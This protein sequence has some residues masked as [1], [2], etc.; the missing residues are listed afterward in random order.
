MQPARQPL[1]NPTMRWFL[2]AMIIANIA[3]EMFYSLLPIYLAE[4]GSSIEQI[5]LV[6][7]LAS[8]AMLVLQLAGGWLSDVIGRLRAVALG[9]VVATLG[10]F[11]LVLAPSWEWAL[12][13]ICL[14]Y[15]SGALVA[16]SFGAFIAEQ[17]TE[18][19]RGRVFGISQ[20][21]FIV[22][23]IIGPPLAGFLAYRFGFKL[24]LLV[25][26]GFYTIASIIRVWMARTMG[27][28]SS[29]NRE[30]LTFAHFRA[31]LR[32]MVSLAVAGGLL[33]WVL[34]TDGVRDVAYR[35]SSDLQP[36][37]FTNVGGLNVEQVG[38]LG[39]ALGAAMM[40]TM[41]PSGW[42]TDRYGERVAIA[43]G[44]LLQ[45]IGL[46]IFLG[47]GGFAWFALSAAVFGSGIGMMSPAYNAL[48][49]KI[50][51]EEQRGMAFG[52]LQSSI[53]IIS[54]PAPWLGAQ[55][56]T[57]FSPRLPFAIT[58]GAALLT[59]IP[60]WLKFKLPKIPSPKIE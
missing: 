19:T 10:Y 30:R 40:L 27:G 7:S 53:G 46:L 56:W 16:P 49:S 47:A 55:L 44:F 5:G 31:S 9:S 42:I 48:T 37:Y 39:S 2:L 18:Q 52:L 59:I 60:V 6:F 11:A 38:W 3:G 28:A 25:A 50:V 57:A 17:S 51:P 26:A 8:V 58:A 36:L 4:L 1:L 15:V 45:F 24:M 43:A 34:L 14:E 23:V 21:I 54:L 13:A 32:A 29:A 35:L 12:A 41:L 20:G 22:V 33:T